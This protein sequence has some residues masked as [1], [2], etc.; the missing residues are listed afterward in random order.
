VSARFDKET[1]RTLARTVSATLEI[2]GP[3]Y[4]IEAVTKF[5]TKTSESAGW[6]EQTSVEYLIRNSCIISLSNNFGPWTLD[7]GLGSPKRG[8]MLRMGHLRKQKG[9]V[10]RPAF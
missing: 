2:S 7:V 4:P 6:V 1:N 5:E 8:E 9:R 3:C 10:F